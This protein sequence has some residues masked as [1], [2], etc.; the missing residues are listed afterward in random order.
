MKIIPQRFK[1]D[2]DWYQV[3]EIIKEFIDPLINLL[4]IDITQPA[5]EIKSEIIG[6]RKAYETLQGFVRSR[7]I[8]KS[9]TL[10]ENKENIFK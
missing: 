7:G 8:E 10:P 2:P 9:N 5:D 1:N 3:E 4:E 6:R